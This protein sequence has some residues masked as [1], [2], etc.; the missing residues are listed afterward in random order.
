MK[1]VRIIHR[2]QDNKVYENVKDIPI[3]IK[4]PAIQQTIEFVM[5]YKEEAKCEQLK[6]S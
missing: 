1:D 4:A 5:N 6:I 2:T 3:D